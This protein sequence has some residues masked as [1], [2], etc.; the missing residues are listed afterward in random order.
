MARGQR[1]WDSNERGKE[2]GT[3]ISTYRGPGK[4]DQLHKSRPR[5][6]AALQTLISGHGTWT[7]RPV[8]PRS[9][10]ANM[11]S[12]GPD[13]AETPLGNS[14]R[15]G[16]SWNSAPAHHTVSR[17]LCPVHTH[18]TGHVQ[19][20]PAPQCLRKA[21]LG[22]RAQPA[23]HRTQTRARLS[24]A[25]LEEHKAPSQMPHRAAERPQSRLIWGYFTPQL[26]CN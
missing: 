11:E 25:G 17:G 4:Q 5:S 12:T 8:L 21:P 16:A 18:A 26:S 22:S 6:G 1:G 3:P 24:W 14:A 9:T 23:C 13:S 20:T 2:P 10:G 7:G 19:P 15:G